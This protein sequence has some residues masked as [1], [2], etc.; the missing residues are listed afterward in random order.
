MSQQWDGL[1]PVWFFLGE[2]KSQTRQAEARPTGILLLPSAAKGFVDLNESKK[3]VEAS[4]REAE[5]GS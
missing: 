1:Q 4:L 2:P 3:F 5:C